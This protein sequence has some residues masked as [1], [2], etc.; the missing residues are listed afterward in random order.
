M[1]GTAGGRSLESGGTAGGW[2]MTSGGTAGHENI[3][4]SVLGTVAIGE[5]TFDIEDTT[6]ACNNEVIAVD[7]VAAFED[8]ALLLGKPKVVPQWAAFPRAVDDLQMLCILLKYGQILPQMFR[9]I[10]FLYK[11]SCQ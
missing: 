2:S 9:K 1:S 4:R 10:V 8:E 7:D 11:N 3:G 5:V 6:D